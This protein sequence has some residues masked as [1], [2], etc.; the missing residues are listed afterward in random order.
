MGKIWKIDNLDVWKH[1]IKTKKKMI[2]KS[3][4]FTGIYLKK[5]EILDDFSSFPH[6]KYNWQPLNLF[7]KDT[8]DQ[9]EHFGG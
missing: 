2:I 5:L 4:F 9:I 7:Q 6:K 1:F 8:R 3:F